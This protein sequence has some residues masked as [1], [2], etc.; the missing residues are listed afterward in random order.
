MKKTYENARA[1]ILRLKKADILT[2]SL[3]NPDW[4]DDNLLTP[5]EDN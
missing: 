5:D 3:D 2:S 4:G 1:D